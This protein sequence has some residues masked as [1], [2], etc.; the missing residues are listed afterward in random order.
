V[1]PA[2]LVDASTAVK[3]VLAE[4]LSQHADALY[5][6]AL[7]Q[8]HPLLGPPHLLGEAVNAIYQ[9]WRTTDPS[10][11]L[12]AAE[13]DQAVADLLRYPWQL[14]APPDLYSQ[15]VAFAH[16]HQLPSVYDSLYVVTAQLMGADFWT[17]DQRLLRAVAAAAPWVR[18][19]GNYP[20]PP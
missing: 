18:W 3:L 19:L 11:H 14:V 13:V 10:K 9:R 17:A 6:D 8:R 16:A 4:P 20:L 1:S 2:Y 12:T 5:Q 15:A 7:Q